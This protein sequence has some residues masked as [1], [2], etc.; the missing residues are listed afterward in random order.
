[1][2]S[3]ANAAV[4]TDITKDPV[5]EMLAG[6]LLTAYHDRLVRKDQFDYIVNHDTNVVRALYLKDPWLSLTLAHIKTKENRRRR[7]VAVHGKKP[8]PQPRICRFCKDDL[9]P[10]INCHCKN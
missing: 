9:W 1:M 10:D 3:K 4:M 5:F 7:I 8:A 2:S 6:G